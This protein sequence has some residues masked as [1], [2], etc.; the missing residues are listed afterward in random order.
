MSP[1]ILDPFVV[2]HD[3]FARSERVIHN[4]LADH[5]RDTHGLGAVQYELR[6]NSGRADL[7]ALDLLSRRPTISV[8]EVK[9]TVADVKAARQ[10]LRYYLEVARAVRDWGPDAR[11]IGVLAAPRLAIAPFQ[12]SPELYWLPV[13]WAA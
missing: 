6:L 8:I 1:Y 3:G 11:V 12:L 13:Q 2:R 7:L 4:Y 10:L 9:R 5:L